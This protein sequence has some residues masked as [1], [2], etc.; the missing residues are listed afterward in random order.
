MNDKFFSTRQISIIAILAAIS[1]VLLMINFPIYLFPGFY[2]IDFSD[3]PCLLCGF[4]FGPLSGIMCVFVSRILNIILEGGSE[5]AYIGEL[6]S[7]LITISFVLISSIIY[8]TNHSKKGA[9]YSL[10]IGVLV[11]SAISMVINYFVLLPMY[12][13]LMNISLDAIVSVASKTIPFVKDKLSFVLFCTLPFNII[14]GT[15]NSLI[16]IFIYKR[17]SPLIKG[18][19]N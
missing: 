17:I 3:L 16:I 1:A 18:T 2:K 10:I 15:V 5:T 8:K 9:I 13:N 19:N 6:A 4:A 11:S 7:L 12:E 14:K